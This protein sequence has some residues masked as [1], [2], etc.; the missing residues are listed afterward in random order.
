MRRRLLIP[1]GRDGEWVWAS[2]LVPPSHWAGLDS[3][4]ASVALGADIALVGCPFCGNSTANGA[5][6]VFTCQGDSM[7]SAHAHWSLAATLTLP[8]AWPPATAQGHLLGM[9]V[10]FLNGAALVGSADRVVYGF[11]LV[12]GAWS[13]PEVLAPLPEL[14]S[15]SPWWLDSISMSEHVAVAT[16]YYAVFRTLHFFVPIDAEN[17]TAGWRHA[18]HHNN[19]VRP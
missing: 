3:F 10:A 2:D 9:G 15:K 17:I 12:N 1:S 6:F 4:G 16:D 18:Q 14:P 13:E 7:R 19:V 11:Y 5:V 8:T